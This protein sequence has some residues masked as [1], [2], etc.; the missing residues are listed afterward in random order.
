MTPNQPQRF[1]EVSYSVKRTHPS[2]ALTVPKYPES[3]EHD[4]AVTL[5]RDV[6]RQWARAGRD[7]LV[8]R[9]HGIYWC[10]DDPSIGIDPDVCIL[11]PAPPPG[12]D[13][14][15]I[16]TWLPGHEPPLVAVE[17]VSSLS[18]LDPYKDY[19]AVTEKHAAC[20][21]RELWL[22]DPELAGPS[23]HAGPYRLQ[24]WERDTEG[25]F[26]RSH[27]GEGPARSNALGAYV[28]VVGRLLRVSDDAAGTALWPTELESLRAR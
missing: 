18:D 3:V 27:A 4:E 23:I 13:R 8:A 25:R 15:C 26:V 21:T 11:A 20:G 5:L 12:W 19:L 10:E 1:T 9:N 16:R 6:L 7:A 17:V 2:W 24:I 14:E 22:F 28:L